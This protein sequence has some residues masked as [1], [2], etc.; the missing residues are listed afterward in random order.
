MITGLWSTGKTSALHAEQRSSILRRPNLNKAGREIMKRLKF[1]AK[2]IDLVVSGKKDTTW[3][4]ND[5][6]NLSVGDELSMCDVNG[7]E[8]GRSKI[9]GVRETTF[10]DLSPEDKAGHESYKSDEE[11]YAAY[12]RYY[13]ISITPETKVKIIKFRLS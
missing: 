4:I 5:D 1:D 13:K 12:F 3:R 6:K 2:L 11:M 8:F 7:K 9:I 10:A